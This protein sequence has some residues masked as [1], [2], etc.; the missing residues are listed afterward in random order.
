M[1][2]QSHD[3]SAWD[4]AGEAVPGGFLSPASSVIGSCLVSAVTA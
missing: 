1:V 4:P 3:L 2:E